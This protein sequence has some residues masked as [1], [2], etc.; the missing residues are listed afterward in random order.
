MLSTA[1]VAVVVGIRLWYVVDG[2]GGSGSR[3][4]AVVCM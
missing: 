4:K 1:A 3:H 2:S